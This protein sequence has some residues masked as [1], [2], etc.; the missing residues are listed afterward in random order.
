[1]DLDFILAGKVLKC[2]MLHHLTTDNGHASSV[3]PVFFPCTEKMPEFSVVIYQV[4]KAKQ[5]A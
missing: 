3:W 2:E 5:P 4:N 1:M